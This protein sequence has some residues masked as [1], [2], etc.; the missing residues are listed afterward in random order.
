MGETLLPAPTDPSPPDSLVFVPAAGMVHVFS[1]PLRGPPQGLPSTPSRIPIPHAPPGRH[2]PPAAAPRQLPRA[3]GIAPCLRPFRG[4][5]C[6]GRPEPRP[7][8]RAA[9]QVAGSFTVATGG[10]RDKGRCFRA[11]FGSRIETLS[12]R[13][14]AGGQWGILSRSVF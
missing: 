5:K 11:P 3:V 8:G 12:R 13:Y 2:C 4:G 1:K 9:R 14:G 7:A 6:G 10:G